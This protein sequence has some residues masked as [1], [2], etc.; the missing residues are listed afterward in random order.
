MKFKIISILAMSLLSTFSFAKKYN[1]TPAKV[2][3]SVNEQKKRHPLT[4]VGQAVFKNGVHI[5]V[6]SISVPMG[7]DEKERQYHSPTVNCNSSKCY[8]AMDLPKDMASH[9]KIYNIAETGQWILAPASWSRME[10]YIGADGN[11]IM[12]ITSSD[13]KANLNLYDV[14]ACVGCA[15]E[16]ASPFFPE[17]AREYQRAFDIKLNTLSTPLHIVRANKK[18]VY[19]QYQLKD[20]YQTNGVS[21]YRPDED[22]PYEE[23]SVTL[24][25]NQIAY[26]RLMLNFF[27][28]THK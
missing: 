4:Y 16:A 7:T 23:M 18:T 10:G 26:A 5:P 8:F 12:T 20:Q 13:Q 28:L 14:P 17:A 3:L 27:A 21:K 15:M 24:P 19:Y 11:T 9:M 6:Y 2:T 25:E 22:N 1:F